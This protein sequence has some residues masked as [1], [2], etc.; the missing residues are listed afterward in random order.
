MVRIE[1]E[2]H[3]AVLQKDAALGAGDAAAEAAEQRVDEADDD[4]DLVQH[5]DVAGDGLDGNR[6]RRGSA[7]RALGVD[8]VEAHGR[9]A[10]WQIMVDRNRTTRRRGGKG[11]D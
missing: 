5:R 6:R 10:G 1:R 2:G 8:E 7:R 4:P 3:A 11:W 9:A